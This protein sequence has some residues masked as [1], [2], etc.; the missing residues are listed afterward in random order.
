VNPKHSA[1][2]ALWELED[3]PRTADSCELEPQTTSNTPFLSFSDIFRCQ[4]QVVY[5]KMD[6]LVRVQSKLKNTSVVFRPL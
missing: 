1:H 6:A 2:F 4:M 5:S 3:P